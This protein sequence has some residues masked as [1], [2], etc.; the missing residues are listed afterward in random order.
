MI[1]AALPRVLTPIPGS[2]DKLVM[3]EFKARYMGILRSNATLCT[4]L[5]KECPELTVIKAD[6][7]MYAMIGIGKY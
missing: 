1:Q 2:S 4:V 6:G 7:A 3:D 5:G